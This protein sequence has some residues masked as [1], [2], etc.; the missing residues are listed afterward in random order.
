MGREIPKMS[1]GFFKDGLR[2]N[3]KKFHPLNTSIKG[4]KLESDRNYKPIDAM[5][6]LSSLS[7]INTGKSTKLDKVNTLKTVLDKVSP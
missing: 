7:S 5:D 3:S 1:L 2:I 4:L 6:I